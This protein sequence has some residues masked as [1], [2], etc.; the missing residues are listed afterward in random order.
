MKSNEGAGS[1]VESPAESTEFRPCAI[2]PSYRHVARLRN[3]TDA[4]VALGLPVFLVDDGNAPE[5]AAV[6]AALA[7]P[8]RRVT[9]IRRDANGGK[10]AAIKTGFAAAHAAGFTHAL[11]V[12]ADGQH[13]LA[14]AP[15]FLEKARAAPGAVIC[16]APRYDESVPKARK[17]GR[18]ITHVC[19]WIET[20]SL[21]ITDSMCGFR[22]YPLASTMRVVT[23]ETIGDRMDFDTEIAVH[24]HWAGAPFVTQ[25]TGVVYPEGNVS[26]FDMLADNVR[27]SWM[28]IRM[29]VQMPVRAPMRML[30]GEAR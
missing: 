27:I 21:D 25:E 15:A 19:V 30:R 3:V 1:P 7:D 20:L 2:V 12:D 8:Q 10:G 9:V 13:D 14:D 18:Y 22:L 29:L 16:G 5:A 6:I 11:Q 17:F 28:H 4:L 23:R 24:L 26:N